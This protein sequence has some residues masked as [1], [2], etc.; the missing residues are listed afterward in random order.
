MVTVGCIAMDLEAAEAE[1]YLRKYQWA[2]IGFAREVETGCPF[3]RTLSD[4][5]VRRFLSYIQQFSAAE[6]REI[7][8][9]FVK[10]YNRP[11]LRLLGEAFTQEDEAKT[12]SHSA[13]LRSISL[14]VLFSTPIGE[15]LA[16]TKTF[17]VKRADTAKIVLS[18]LSAAFGTKPEKRASLEWF[19]TASFGDWRIQTD[20][21]FSG[22]WGTEIR[23]SHRLIRKDGKSWGFLM[24]PLSS[25]VGIVRVPQNFS[26]LTLYGISPGIYYIG[27]IDDVHSAAQAILDSYDRL[28][29]AV[30]M[31]I[32]GLT[33][34]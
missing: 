31:W 2:L 15:P 3:L 8:T 29:Q 4:P 7:T 26:L 9:L 11:A 30:P 20:L 10:S 34:N 33:T 5:S 25:A 17:A 1:L 12:R 28:F 23:C 24:I 27:S 16:V 19:Y 14:P 13:S 21:D 32:D 22:T 18:F 6:Q